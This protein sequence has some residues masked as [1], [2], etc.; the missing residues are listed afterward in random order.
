ML[1]LGKDKLQ[2]VPSSESDVHWW[3]KSWLAELYSA[4]WKD[5]SDL[6]AQF[7]K[8]SCTGP[9]AFQFR[10]GTDAWILELLV[11]FPQNLALV[12]R[13]ERVAA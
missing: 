10:V 11:C 5:P 7:P 8:V 4:N 1:V 13:M 9:N 2:I 6:L 3:L 12:V